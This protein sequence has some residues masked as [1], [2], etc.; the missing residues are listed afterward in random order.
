MLENYKKLSHHIEEKNVYFSR[1]IAIDDNGY[2][3][4]HKE[5]LENPPNDINDMTKEHIITKVPK[6]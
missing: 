6:L 1:C 5:F 2:I 4:V 3:I